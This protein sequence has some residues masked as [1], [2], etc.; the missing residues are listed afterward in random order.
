M[1][2]LTNSHLSISLHVPHTWSKTLET[3]NEVVKS[4]DPQKTLVFSIIFQGCRWG[5]LGSQHLSFFIAGHVLRR[6]IATLATGK[7][8]TM[9]IKSIRSEHEQHRVWV[10]NEFP[11]SK[12]QLQIKPTQIQSQHMVWQFERKNSR[13]HS[14]N[15]SVLLDVWYPPW[16]LGWEWWW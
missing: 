12:E 9:D 7:G 4:L 16:V 15:I 1:P 13:M 11:P 2:Y 8:W 10:W 5:R 3:R 14:A 6:S